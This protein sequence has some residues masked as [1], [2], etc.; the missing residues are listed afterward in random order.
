MYK[1]ILVP[2]DGSAVSEG[3]AEAAI[4]LAK[5]LGA[6]ITAVHVLP[7]P[8]A[9]DIDAWAH[10]DPHFD[11]HLQGVLEGRGALYLESVR[12]AAFRAG[13]PCE[14]RLVK[15]Q[16]PYAR[17]LAEAREHECDLIFMASHGRRGGDGTLLASE[18][19]KTATFGTVP[20]LIHH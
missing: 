4:V 2:T 7:E 11:R 13:V 1:H 5:T 10:R 8:V 15:D 12:D 3:A 20:V 16:S 19:L 14:C 17:I 9:T 6:R 18:T